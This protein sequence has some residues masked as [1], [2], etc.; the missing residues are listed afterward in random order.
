MTATEPMTATETCPFHS[1]NGPTEAPDH[2]GRRGQR[3][4]RIKAL[5]IIGPLR[6]F[7][8]DVL[9]F[10][11]ETRKTYGDA[12]RFRILGLELTCIGGRDAI[13]LLETDELLST[14]KS[15]GVLQRALKSRL[16]MTFD[17]PQH[18]TYRKVHMRFLNRSLEIAKRDE[19]IGAVKARTDRWQVG[20]SFGV[21]K[22]SQSQTVH[23]LSRILNCEEF[24]FSDE[25]LS[26]VVHT[27]ILATYGHLPMWI[28]L[29]NPAYKAAMKRMS[30]HFLGLVRRVR[31]DPVLA[32][33]SMIGQYLTAPLPEGCSEW[34]DDDLKTVPLMAYLAGFDTVA[35]ASGFLL[36][37]LL[38]NPEWLRRVREEY[39]ELIRDG[40]GTVDPLR[41]KILRAA[42]QETVR[43]NPPGALVVRYATKD[44]AFQGYSIR[45]GDEVL[46]Q[47]SSDHLD[48]KL[49]PDPHRYDPA[50][51]LAE[52]SARLR[53]RVLTFG[54]GA[55]RCT[56]SVV[57]PL[58]SQEMVSHWINH[59][60]L[61]LDPH[62]SK[63]KV[64]ALPFTQPMGLKVRIR[65][66]RT[67]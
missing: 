28:A 3:P 52:D 23:I 47:I 65:G 22:E 10:L 64:M 27:V 19:I 8:G 42:F 48:E 1:A 14:T 17:G 34:E 21:L 26:L 16:P 15:M 36:Y 46:I 9:P 53:H 35:S 20:D 2:A 11:T 13:A 57:G 61:E 55:H 18:D 7:T 33:N 32:A 40:D 58:I 4:P 12:F 25:D 51:F 54:S 49:F 31:Q 30:D 6:Q 5:P 59:Y 44:F 37:R 24:P 45:K 66:R 41:Q 67:P 62:A 60:D 38:S 50:R 43:L 56:G 39:S 29:N 63:P